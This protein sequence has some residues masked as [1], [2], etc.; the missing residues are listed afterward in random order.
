MLRKQTSFH[1]QISS[2]FHRS[3]T[4]GD[5]TSPKPSY[6]LWIPKNASSSSACPLGSE[7][8]LCIS[9]AVCSGNRRCSLRQPKASSPNW[10]RIF[11]K[12][13]L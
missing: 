11:P 5:E 7:S 10:S 1:H 4:D 2:G 13:G 12:S 6:E 3:L 9:R 8:P